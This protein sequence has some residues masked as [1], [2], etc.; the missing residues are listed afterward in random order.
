MGRLRIL[1]MAGV[2]IALYTTYCG[3]CEIC[4]K[5]V[6]IWQDYK[7]RLSEK[8]HLIICYEHGECARKKKAD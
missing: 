3:A 4:K 2:G 5:S 1:L 7:M 8:N 6:W